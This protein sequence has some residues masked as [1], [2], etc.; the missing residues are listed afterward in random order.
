MKTWRRYWPAAGTPTLNEP[1][2]AA[3]DGTSTQSQRL[4]S[5]LSRHIEMRAKATFVASAAGDS[6]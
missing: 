5:G 6:R 3:S 4:V 2:L 1:V